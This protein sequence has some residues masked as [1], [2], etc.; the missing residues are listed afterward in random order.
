MVKKVISI[1][2]VL[3]FVAVLCIYPWPADAAGIIITVA[4]IVF[5]AAVGITV[6]RLFGGDA[7]GGEK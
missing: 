7:H 3:L 2:A 6:F 4:L 1:I 5:S